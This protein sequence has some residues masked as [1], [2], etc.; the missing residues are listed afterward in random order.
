M[1]SA[2]ITAFTQRL[3]IPIRANKTVTHKSYFTRVKIRL[4][5]TRAA[6]GTVYLL[7]TT[8]G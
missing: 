2:N 4:T 3:T 6:V 7:L 1:Y 8:N 5:K